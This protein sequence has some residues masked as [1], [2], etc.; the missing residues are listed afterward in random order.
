LSFIRK[1]EAKILKA[2][3]KKRLPPY[4]GTWT[5]FGHDHHHEIVPGQQPWIEHKGSIVRTRED[6]CPDHAIEAFYGRMVRREAASFLHGH[7]IRKHFDLSGVTWKTQL[8]TSRFGSCHPSKQTIK[9][10]TCLGRFD[11]SFLHATVLHEIV[12]LKVNNHG[13][14]FYAW[15][16]SYMPDYKTVHRALKQ[17]FNRYEVK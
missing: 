14:R 15:L 9:L 8:M 5:I 3:D 10:N 4:D 13:E 6:V 16:L 2:A 11:R 12:H 17:T 7:P 1:N